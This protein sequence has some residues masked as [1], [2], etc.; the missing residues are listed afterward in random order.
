M[1]RAFV[2]ELDDQAESQLPER[3][4]SP[5]TNY[6]TPEGFLNLQ[7]QVRHYSQLQKELSSNDDLAGI[8]QLRQIERDLHYFQERVRRAVVVKS[9]SQTQDK[10]HFGATVEVEDAAGQRNQLTIV[11]EDETNA[12]AGKISW[13]S[14][15]ASAL[16]DCEVG[17][18]VIWKRPAG[19]K[20]LTIIAIH[21][22]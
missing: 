13:V 10:V 17:E 16:L 6:I 20:E 7:E 22:S 1:S 4:Q 15:L 5:H 19:D 14:P 18:T 11:G 3:P 8:Q 2:K 21:Q 9:D 12:A